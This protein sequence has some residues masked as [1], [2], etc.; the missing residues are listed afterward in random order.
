VQ[1]VLRC[2]KCVRGM[3]IVGSTGLAKQV[4]K[5]AVCP[6]CRTKNKVEW[7]RGDAFRVQRIATR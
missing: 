7:P 6:Y 4:K 1:K 3:R 5:T 2:S